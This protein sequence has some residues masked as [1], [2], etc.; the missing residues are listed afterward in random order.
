MRCEE[1]LGRVAIGLGRGVGSKRKRG[2]LGFRGAIHKAMPCVAESSSASEPFGFLGDSG[3]AS[4][5]G[6]SLEGAAFRGGGLGRA[7]PVC[8]GRSLPASAGGVGDQGNGGLPSLV[9]VS[10]SSRIVAGPRFQIP[11]PESDSGFALTT[12]GDGAL[13]FV[14]LGDD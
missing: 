3:W 2:Q 6:M 5:W 12:A 14:E 7:A 8:N 4:F 11:A 1:S 9:W 13:F 10:A